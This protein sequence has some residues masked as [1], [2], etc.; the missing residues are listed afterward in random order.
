M[1]ESENFEVEYSEYALEFLEKSDRQLK[2]SIL[3]K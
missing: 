3:K 2:K 1:R